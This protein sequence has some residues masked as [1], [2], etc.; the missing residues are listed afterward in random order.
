LA[1]DIKGTGVSYGFPA[2]TRTGAALELSAKEQDAGVLNIQLTELTDYLG[3]VK[4]S[5]KV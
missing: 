1:H 2:L 4:L 3:R 5:V